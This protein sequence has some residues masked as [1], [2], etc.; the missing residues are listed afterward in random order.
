MTIKDWIEVGFLASWI[1]CLIGV[2]VFSHLHFKNKKLKL[3]RKVDQLQILIKEYV[4]KAP[5]K[6]AFF[7]GKE[8]QNEK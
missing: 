6:G 8:K 7:D 3:Q 2:G 1:V 4:K 5:A